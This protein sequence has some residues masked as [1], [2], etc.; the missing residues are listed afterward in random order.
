MRGC[1]YSTQSAEL[2]IL[3]IFQGLPGKKPYLFLLTHLW[4]D[5]STRRCTL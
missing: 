5:H 2:K 4:V 3:P 1:Y